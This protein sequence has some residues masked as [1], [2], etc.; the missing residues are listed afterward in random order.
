MPTMPKG[1]TLLEVI[2]SAAIIVTGIVSLVTLIVYIQTSSRLTYQEAIAMGL[3]QEGIEAARF[4]RDSNWLEREAGSGANFYDG[5]Y[6]AMTLDYTAIYRWRS[7]MSDPA[8]AVAFDFAPDS[9][10]DAAAIVY[11]TG[12]NQYRQIASSPPGGWKATP[13]TRFMTLYPICSD[14]GG[15]TESLITADGQS[16][17]T[18][19]AGTTQIG[20]QAVVEVSWE[21]SGTVHTR[22]LEERL[23]DWKYAD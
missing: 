3:A 19:F 15:I 7:T 12:S 17:A 4:V 9:A 20:V 22:T 2:I 10:T 11:M 5:L 13:Y 1:Q 21:N 23:Y 14:D 18:T 16:C 6:D 8:V